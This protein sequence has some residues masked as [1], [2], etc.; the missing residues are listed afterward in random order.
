MRPVNAYSRHGISSIDRVVPAKKISYWQLA[1]EQLQKNEPKTYEALKELRGNKSCCSEV[2]PSEMVNI[3]QKQKRTMEERQW[4]LPFRVRGREIKIRD[5]LDTVLKVL[6]MFKDFG[7]VL[8]NLDPVH[9]GIPWAG[10]NIILQGAL[11][12]SEQHSAA[13]SGLAQVSPIVARYTEVEVMYIQETNT[14]LEK[15]FED[16]IVSLYSEILKYQV[17]AACHCKRSTFQ[18]FL[19]ALPKLDDWNGMIENIKQKDADC[20]KMT[21]VFDSQDQRL[22][23]FKLQSLAEKNDKMMKA[24]LQTLQEIAEEQKKENTRI[25]RWIC[26]HVAGRDHQ[27]ILVQGKMGTEYA[28]SGQWLIRNPKFEEW[29]SIESKHYSS[30]WVCGPVGCGKSSLISCVI[31]WHLQRLSFDHLTQVAYFYCSRTKGE[32]QDRGTTPETVMSSIVS[33]LLWSP[34]GSGIAKRISNL[35][36]SS[37]YERP[38]EARLSLDESANIVDE[39]TKSWSQTTIIIDALDECSQP[40]PLLRALKKV[41]EGSAGRVRLFMSSRMNVEV[42]DVFVEV[43]RVDIQVEDT[44]TDVYKYIW[45]E[46]KESDRR[47]LKGREPEL[48]DRMIA[49]LNNR[50]QGM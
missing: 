20:R 37:K 4:A 36:T 10:V 43:S 21:R 23:N 18:R 15:E 34:D 29:A 14:S 27:S 1:A 16:G 7:S 2:L 9:V 19:R 32:A 31:E 42:S 44:A 25:P 45:K 40:Y 5:Q 46:L 24:F 35:Y 3:I 47:L 28:G 49:T 22:V 33:Q 8:S 6:Q 13:L 38:D 48:E 39:L 41:V 12:D 11:N 26:H 17:A 50:A 30:F